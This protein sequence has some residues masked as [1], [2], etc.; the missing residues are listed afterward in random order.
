MSQFEDWMLTA[1]VLGELEPV[2]DSMV[3]QALTSDVNLQNEVAEIRSTLDTVRG[4][5]QTAAPNRLSRTQTEALRVSMLKRPHQE[6]AVR[7]QSRSCIV[8][9][10]FHFDGIMD[11]IDGRG[12]EWTGRCHVRPGLLRRGGSDCIS[13]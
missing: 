12:G 2:Q 3:E 10:H 8:A 4:A 13:N 9:V 6:T 11:G 1:Y 7:H 5:L